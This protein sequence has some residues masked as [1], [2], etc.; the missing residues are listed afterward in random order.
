MV[1]NK[2]ETKADP[3]LHLAKLQEAEEEIKKNFHKKE[4]E[5][6]QLLEELKATRKLVESASREVQAFDDAKIQ[7]S[8]SDL[9]EV[10]DAIDSLEVKLEN[11]QTQKKKLSTFDN[12]AAIYAS[13]PAQQL[14]VSIDSQTIASLYG[15]ADKKEWSQEESEHFL[16]MQ[17]AVKKTMQYSDEISAPFKEAVRQTYDA[18]KVVQDKQKDQIS[19]AYEASPFQQTNLEK[20]NYQSTNISQTAQQL[21]Q[22]KSENSASQTK[23]AQP[24]PLESSVNKISKQYD[25]K[26]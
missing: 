13:V 16:N 5:L 26:K 24:S 4:K 23:T 18:L 6:K 3:H 12:S 15:L 17:Y 21:Q 19:K 14:A 8:F 22:T 20:K 10:E 11:V 25:A 7:S 1:K 2:K 9:E